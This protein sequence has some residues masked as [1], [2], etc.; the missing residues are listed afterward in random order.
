MSNGSQHV[1]GSVLRALRRQTYPSAEAFAAACGSVSVPTVYRAERGGRVLRPYLDRMAAILGVT[2]E[3]L[4]SP[5]PATACPDITGDWFGLYVCTDHFGRPSIL[6]EDA[7]FTQDGIRVAGTSAHTTCDRDRCDTFVDCTFSN[8]VFSGRIVSEDWPAP[9]DSPVFVLTGTRDMT[10]LSGYLT[11]FDMDSQR[12]EVSRYFLIRKDRPDFEA[13]VADARR[14]LATEIRLHL[15]RK[16]LE[17][18][19]EFDAALRAVAS[20]DPPQEAPPPG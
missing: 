18:G 5:A 17:A 16:S 10:W 7:R 3:T 11:W 2:A 14:A 4:L 19:L 6:T 8:N 20:R 15:L 13:D 1:N 12:A 9:L